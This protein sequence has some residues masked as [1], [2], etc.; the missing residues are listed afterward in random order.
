MTTFLKFQVGNSKLGK[1]IG[2]FSLPAGFSCPSA[3]EC[4]AKAVKNKETGKV[5]IQSGPEMKFWCFAAGDEAKY[6]STYKARHHNFDIL[7]GLKH[8]ADMAEII[9]LSLPKQNIIRVHVSGDFFNQNYFDAWMQ[10]AKRNPTKLFYAYTKSLN[11]WV[12]SADLVPE[13][14]KL[15]ASVG[16]KLDEL[17]A[18]HELKYAKVVYTPEQAESENLE[19][20]HDDTHAYL[21]NDS[22]ALLIH[23]M[24]PK[25]SEASKAIKELKARGVKFSY[26]GKKTKKLKLEK[27]GA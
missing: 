20:D 27:V 14:F 25:G 10:V 4:L 24:Q 16:G 13:N 19:I 18:Q 26:K 8:S 11:Y 21:K 15:N 23:G 12:S 7:R 9:H 2:T 5:S 3:N 1:T 6:P 17:I 22:F